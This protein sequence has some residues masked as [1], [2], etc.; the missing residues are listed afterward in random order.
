LQRTA[1]GK[2]LIGNADAGSLQLVVGYDASGDVEGIQE[3]VS[4]VLNI[5]DGFKPLLIG[6]VILLTERRHRLVVDK[7]VKTVFNRYGR[8]SEWVSLS[9]CGVCLTR[10]ERKDHVK[11][12]LGYLGKYVYAVS[13]ASR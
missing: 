3:N 12:T 6:F 8:W 10:P 9:G 4:V 11:H 5:R 7:K 2:T 1:D 13:V